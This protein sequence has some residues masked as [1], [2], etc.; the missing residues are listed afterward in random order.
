M[1]NYFLYTDGA[2]RNNQ[3]ADKRN[4]KCGIGGVLKDSNNITVMSFSEPIRAG[5]NNVAEYGAFCYGICK[6][7]EFFESKNILNDN[8]HLTI[9]TDSLLIVNQINGNINVNEEKLK[10]L[11]IEAKKLVK[12]I[13]T[14]VEH[15]RRE[16]NAEADYYANKGIERGI[17]E[18]YYDDQWFGN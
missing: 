7:Y 16:F 10:D 12:V 9:R 15:I 18:K 6:S 3:A 1:R 5:S 17:A 11:Y 14:K 4:L 8:T 13:P 2:A